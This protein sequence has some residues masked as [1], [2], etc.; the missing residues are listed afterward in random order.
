M[1]QLK[2]MIVWLIRFKTMPKT[3]SAAVHRTHLALLVRTTVGEQD[4]RQ[5]NEPEDLQKEP[6]A[7]RS[8]DV[9]PVVAV[10][11]A[12]DLDDEIGQKKDRRPF[13][14]PHGQPVE[15]LVVELSGLVREEPVGQALSTITIEIPAMIAVT[16]SI[17]E[18]T[19]NTTADAACSAS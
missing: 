12:D 9:A 5:K 17:P 18:Y 10:S 6:V 2:A 8:G 3:V 11:H 7:V 13:T 1:F 15:F 4:R 19:T 16:K 14:E